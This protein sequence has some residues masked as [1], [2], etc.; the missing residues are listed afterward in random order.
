MLLL[1][2]PPSFWAVD[3]KDTPIESIIQSEEHREPGWRTLQELLESYKE[4][5]KAAMEAADHAEAG[6]ASK[7]ARGVWT[8]LNSLLLQADEISDKIKTFDLNVPV[9]AGVATTV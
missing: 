1:R 6:V 7:D 3:T 2:H 5:L 9:A 4:R 8:K